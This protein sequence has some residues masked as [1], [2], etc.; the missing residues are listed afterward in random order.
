MTDNEKPKLRYPSAF[1]LGVV[2]GCIQEAVVHKHC[3]E[4]LSARPF[5]YVRMG[6]IWGFGL[7]YFDYWRRNATEA[8]LHKNE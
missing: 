2:T 4:P 3:Y 6:L 8:V 7:M 5:S 1:M